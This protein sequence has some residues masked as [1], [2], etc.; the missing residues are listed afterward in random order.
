MEKAP[1]TWAFGGKHAGSCFCPVCT[2]IAGFADPRTF[3]R[4]IAYAGL[5]SLTRFSTP[6]IVST[7]ACYAAEKDIGESSRA[8]NSRHDYLIFGLK[9]N[10]ALR[11]LARTKTFFWNVNGIFA[12]EVQQ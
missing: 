8:L 6:S 1:L 7:N 4:P 11:R 2:T 12:P 10:I 9:V 5:V 3:S